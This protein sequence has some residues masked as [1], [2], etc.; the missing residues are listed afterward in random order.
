MHGLTAATTIGGVELQDSAIIVRDSPGLLNLYPEFVA[1]LGFPRPANGASYPIPDLLAQ[2]V[3]GHRVWRQATRSKERFIS[4]EEIEIVCDSMTR[5]LWLRLYLGRGDLSRYEITR[6]QLLRDGDLASQFAEVRIT[7]TGRDPTW[8]CLEQTT[9]V[10][11]TGRPTDVVMNL[12][13]MVRPLLWRIATTMPDGAYRKY[14]VHLT[15]PSESASR[16]P[17]LASLWLLFYYFGSVVR[18]RPHLFHSVIGGSF[19]PSWWSSSL[20]RN[21]CSTSWRPRW[22]SVRS[23]S[24]RSSN[25]SMLRGR[26]GATSAADVRFTA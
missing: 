8:L 21:S 24:P 26:V 9:P 1:R 18:Y 23:P 16:V 5:E 12:V 10:P 4:I 15:P 2:I 6:A 13:E 19:G 17:Q 11:Y 3:V 20:R 14:Y 22:P 7:G 25:E